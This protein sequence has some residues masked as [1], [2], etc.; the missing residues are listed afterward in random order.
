MKRRLAALIAMVTA[1]ARLGFIGEGANLNAIERGVAL[2]MEQ[3][4]GM[5]LGDVR[6]LGD[7]PS[8]LDS[9]LT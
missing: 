7:G 2:M 8:G 9:K 1:L 4:H 3:Y 5:T 6:D